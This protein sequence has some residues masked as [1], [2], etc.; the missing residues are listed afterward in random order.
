MKRTD[1]LKFVLMMT[2]ATP[3]FAETPSPKPAIKSAGPDTP[4]LQ[5]NDI[6]PA[7]TQLTAT[8]KDGCVILSWLS[9]A[10]KHLIHYAT[11]S[12]DEVTE[13][14]YMPLG[15]NNYKNICVSD[16][17]QEVIHGLESGQIYFFIVTAVGDFQGSA[18]REVS[19]VA[20][21]LTC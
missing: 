13:E 19:I 11:M 1:Y 9:D 20:P 18:S 12:F 16:K 5:S 8:T 21:A 15:K 2:L 6:L 17:N 14:N 4:A 7:P 10:D 3:A